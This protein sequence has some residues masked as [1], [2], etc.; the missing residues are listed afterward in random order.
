MQSGFDNERNGAG[1][2]VIAV[3][4][5]FCTETLLVGAGL[6]AVLQSEAPQ[7]FAIDF[8]TNT[9]ENSEFGIHELRN[10]VKTIQNRP[11]Y[12]RERA[13]ERSEVIHFIFSFASLLEARRGSPERCSVCPAAPRRGNRQRVAEVSLSRLCFSQ[14]HP[15]PFAWEERT[16]L[17]SFSYV[18][19]IQWLPAHFELS[20]HCMST[21][22]LLQ[23]RGRV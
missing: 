19:D 16:A 23:V 15:F 4:D 9:E 2:S 10:L 8:V 17:C 22:K 6:D 11:R 5:A 13:S 12:S 1:P 7:K 21:A 14:R 18:L 20:Y 3:F